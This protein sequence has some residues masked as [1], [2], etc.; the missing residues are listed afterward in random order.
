MIKDS[1]IPEIKIDINTKL[2]LTNLP[3][4]KYK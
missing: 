4:L 2:Y 1:N 3:K